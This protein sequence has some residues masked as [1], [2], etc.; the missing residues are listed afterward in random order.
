[1]KPT[2]VCAVAALV[3]LPCPA[4]AQEVFAPP[5]WTGFYAGAGIGAGTAVHGQSVDV[6]GFGTVF[7]DSTGGQ[8]LLASVTAG[9][10]YRVLPNLVFGAFVDFDWSGISAEVSDLS[11]SFSSAEHRHSWAVGAR[12]GYLASP[13]TLLYLAGGYSQAAFTF[14]TL[15]SLDFQGYFASAGIETQLAGNWWVRGEY[16]FTQ[17]EALTVDLCGCASLD[18]ETSMQTGRLLL[19]YRFDAG[20]GLPPP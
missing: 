4:V 2:I 3:L 20:G 1:M 13:A 16:R 10:D 17:F 12:V 14:D 19:I 15:G 5:P 11:A 7:S 6:A 8:G 9:Y 18:I